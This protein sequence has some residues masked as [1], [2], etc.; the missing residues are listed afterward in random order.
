[1]TIAQ[2][3]RQSSMRLDETL[4]HVPEDGPDPDFVEALH[5]T[6]MICNCPEYSHAH[7]H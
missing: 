5:D 6:L 1:V 7:R 4:P 2:I 3:I